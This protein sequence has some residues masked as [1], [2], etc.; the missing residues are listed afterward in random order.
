M[1]IQISVIGGSNPPSWAKEA[2]EEVGRLIAKKG[3]IL[4]CGGMGGVMKSACRGAKSEGGLTVGIIPYYEKERA[5]SYLDVVIPTG[6]GLSRNTLVVASGDVVIAIDGNWGTFSEIA[7]AKNLG[8]GVVAL[9]VELEL[10]GVEYVDTPEEAVRIA[11]ELIG[12]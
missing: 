11:F 6:L 5:N 7:L 4:I 9:G 2:S 10:A 1:S 8:K 3:A 12:I